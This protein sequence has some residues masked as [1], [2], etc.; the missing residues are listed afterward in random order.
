[1]DLRSGNRIQAPWLVCADY[2]VE[3]GGVIE[4]PS[5]P[6]ETPTTGLLLDPADGGEPSSAEVARSAE[7]ERGV[8]ESREHYFFFVL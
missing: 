5:S 2:E 1:M 6:E 4:I 3:G 8:A 7:V